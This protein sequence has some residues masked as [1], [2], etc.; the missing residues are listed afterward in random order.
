MKIL[1]E[2]ATALPIS[3]YGKAKWKMTRKEQQKH[4]YKPD[5]PDTLKE[6]EIVAKYLA[7]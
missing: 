2:L 5:M 7:F 6:L 3:D 1:N 4:Y